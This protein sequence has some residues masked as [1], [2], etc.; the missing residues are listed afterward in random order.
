MIK[1]II[2]PSRGQVFALEAQPGAAISTLYDEFRNR[3]IDPNEMSFVN[4]HTSVEYNRPDAQLPTEGQVT[5]VCSP[6]QPKGGNGAE[7]TYTECREFLKAARAAANEEDDEELLEI[8]GNYTRK[9]LLEL[10]Q[11]VAAVNAYRQAK[12][13]NQAVESSADVTALQAQLDG[14]AVRLAL[15]EVEVGIVTPESARIIG[16]KTKAFLGL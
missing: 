6:L 5:I 13:E 12:Q 9:T 10:K 4:L 1:V 11:T 15:V 14:L 7:L 3:G 8:I 16:E 2:S